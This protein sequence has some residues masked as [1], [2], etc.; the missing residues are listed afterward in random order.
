MI[1]SAYKKLALSIA[2]LGFVGA[3]SAVSAVDT[4]TFNAG[5]LGATWASDQIDV[6][7]EFDHIFNFTAGTS[8]TLSS[9]V[10]VNF[11]NDISVQYRFGS[12][13]PSFQSIN[14][15][16]IAPV[17]T[18]SDGIFSYSYILGGLT[19]GQGYSF[20]IKGAGDAFY[21][22]TLAPV[23]EPESFAMLL[24][25]LGLMGVVARR[26]KNTATVAGE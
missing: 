24:A 16:T 1:N 18:D 10:G 21:S 19:A 23:P 8:S 14:W 26:K 13:G 2:L 20:E 17:P 15:D 5:A 3:A 25:G 6:T 12:A 4:R 7:G 9:I 11:G 22:V